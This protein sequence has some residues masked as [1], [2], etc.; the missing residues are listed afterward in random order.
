M[1]GWHGLGAVNL[2]VWLPWSDSFKQ[3]LFRL[4]VPAKCS[5]LITLLF[6][7]LAQGYASDQSAKGPRKSYAVSQNIGEPQNRTLKKSEVIEL[8]LPKGLEEALPKGSP[9]YGV[10]LEAVRALVLRPSLGLKSSIRIDEKLAE[11]N[12][13]HQF[14]GF[15][16]AS[17]TADAEQPSS[18]VDR[19]RKFEAEDKVESISIKKPGEH[20]LDAILNAASNSSE[21]DKEYKVF[22]PRRISPG[23]TRSNDTLDPVSYT[24][25]TLPTKA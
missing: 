11:P 20:V 2:K 21:A 18:N 8:K 3:F 13:T 5:F 4:K 14:S 9:E 16:N 12:R 10:K 6:A 23:S 15:G 22:A 24:H 19:G 1:I 17:N 25:L 7:V